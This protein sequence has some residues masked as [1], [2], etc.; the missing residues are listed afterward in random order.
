ML[1]ALLHN[2]T[3]ALGG[4]AADASWRRVVNAFL[5]LHADVR[6]CEGPLRGK[7]APGGFIVWKFGLDD[8]HVA[9]FDAGQPIAAGSYGVQLFPSR[10]DAEAAAYGK[11]FGP[12]RVAF[13]S[14]AAEAGNRTVITGMGTF[15][16]DAP[17]G[18]LTSSVYDG[19]FSMMVLVEDS[20]RFS[21][22]RPSE[23][24]AA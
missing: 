22:Q 5:R 13:A 18:E 10:E 1:T 21:P 19:S 14:N 24:A 7:Y 15:D 11:R 17:A 4:T 8:R 16:A 3:S 9:E 6:F 20:P 2:L 23:R 12:E